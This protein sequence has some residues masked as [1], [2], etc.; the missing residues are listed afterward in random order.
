MTPTPE[1]VH[2][3]TVYTLLLTVTVGVTMGRVFSTERLYEPSLHR[4]PEEE[5]NGLQLWPTKRPDPWP[6]FG[7]NDR[8]RWALVRALVDDGTF[9]I[10]RRSMDMTIRSAAGTFADSD[11]L[12]QLTLQAGWRQLRIKSDSGIIS[13]D[14]F[15]TVDKVLHPRTLEFYSTKPPLLA[16]LAAGEYWVLKHT[17][18][19]SIV[20]DRFLVIP[21]ILLT[22]NVV[23]L[24]VYVWVLSLLLE[25]WGTTAWGRYYIFAAACFG[26]MV[27]P[28]QISFNNH[29]IATCTALI[30]IYATVRVRE[31]GN[32]WGWL[33]LAGF[34]AGLTACNELPAT[35]LAVGFGLYL[36]AH[37]PMGALLAFVPAALVPVAALGACNLAELGSLK[38][39]YAEFGGPWYQYEGSHW[40]VVPGYPRRGIDWADEHKAVYA[41][42]LLVGHHGVFT[43]TPIF[44]LS[45]VGMGVAVW[46]L[47]ADLLARRASQGKEKPLLTLRANR[48]WE[49][50]TAFTLVLSIVVI[51]FYIN[52][53]NNYG[54]W[55]N[56]PRWLMWLTPL[57]LLA[58]VPVADRLSRWRMGRGVA[59]LFLAISILSM[60][61]QSWSPWRHP[62]LYGL[63]QRWEWIK[64]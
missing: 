7:S 45:A 42:H 24:I 12:S 28:F 26:T 38:P 50:L 54:G 61:Y 51:A 32:T 17:L 18:G 64:Y 3:R 60:S 49:Q 55:T 43:L 5:Y 4:L 19:W 13:E 30:A 8:S 21:T 11:P 52:Q 57:W 47:F 20:R 33:T 63:M 56:G 29:T 39:A 1:S 2:R 15:Q 14:G 9:V 35:A 16:V 37:R 59:L 25:R 22:F 44:L 53:T 40:V 36:L 46:R 34:M 23:P 6:T 31:G 41:M 27:T 62:W 48:L 10:G 58:I